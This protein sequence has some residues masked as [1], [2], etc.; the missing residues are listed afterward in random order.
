MTLLETLDP[1]QMQ[2]ALRMVLTAHRHEREVFDAVFRDH[3]LL[4]GAADQELQPLVVKKPSSPNPPPPQEERGGPPR[5][6]EG[7]GEGQQAQ[8][9]RQQGQGE[10]EGDGEGQTL[11]S[12]LSPHAARQEAGEGYGGELEDL[13]HAAS[14]L[15][16]RV[17]LGRSRRWRAMPKGRRFDLRR[18]LRAS[19]RTG[20]DP[21]SVRYQGHPRR[22]PR[23][24]IVLDGSRSMEP[25]AALLL[26]YAAALMLRSRRVEV[27]SFST[28]L[29][30][31]TPMLRRSL[32]VRGGERSVWSLK[33]P[34]LGEG[35]GGG[36]RIGDNLLR[37]TRDERAR[38][39]PDT[40][41]LVLS[42]G[43]DTGEPEVLTRA[44]RELSRQSGRLIWLNP[45]A[46]IPGYLPI[47]RGMAAAL[48]YLDVFA[49]ADDV[50][51]LER[52]PGKL[53]W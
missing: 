21:V 4:R 25:H 11:R 27:Y 48:P 41:T 28:G 36:T 3:F 45:L 23:F 7:E 26:R 35:W 18:T 39:T 52:L 29:T 49:A 44:V 33:L 30:R 8:S 19:L 37:L 15:I 42:D 47:A 31:L 46:G 32:G 20:G 5:E 16:R 9:R 40:V 17:R 6:Q 34:D 14:A 22:A 50:A 51:A 12:Q 1:V 13:L 24:L 43:L 53:Q 38:L 10:D 2:D